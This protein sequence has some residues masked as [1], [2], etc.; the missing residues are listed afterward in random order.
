MKYGHTLVCE[1]RRDHAR[2]H[3]AQGPA[4]EGSV[5]E[6]LGQE[7]DA[8]LRLVNVQDII[9]GIVRLEQTVW[10]EVAK[11]QMQER[12][13]PI[14][15]RDPVDVGSDRG[16]REDDDVTIPQNIFRRRS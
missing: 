16:G 7:V 8:R 15:G 14:G 12:S 2:Q 5:P 1:P 10:R 3:L 4:H 6:L 9:S 11:R 13:C